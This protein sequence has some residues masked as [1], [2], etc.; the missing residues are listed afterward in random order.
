MIPYQPPIS[1][2][3]KEHSTTSPMK[4]AFIRFQQPLINEFM[5]RITKRRIRAHFTIAQ[6]IISTLRNIKLNR[7]TSRHNP[8]TLPVTKRI[9]PTMSTRTPF[10]NFS[11]VQINVDRIISSVNRH[12]WRTVFT[13][14]VREGLW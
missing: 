2:S 4:E 10:I 14:L 12:T 9:T 7:S 6:F 13:F 1:I 11:S 5:R 3:S 8:F